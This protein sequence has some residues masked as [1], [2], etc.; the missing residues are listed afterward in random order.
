MGELGLRLCGVSLLGAFAIFLLR[1]IKGEL[2]L[3]VRLG[4]GVL[5]AFLIVSALSP[6]LQELSA[7]GDSVGAQDYVTV[8]LRALGIAL[9]THICAGVCRDLGEG[10]IGVW[11]EMAGKVEIL[12]LC[13]PLLREILKAASKL[14]DFGA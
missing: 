12:L 4:T 8:L 3:T 11:V 10:S 14:L 5:C 6:V 2:A 13:L 7:L 9:L 1:Q